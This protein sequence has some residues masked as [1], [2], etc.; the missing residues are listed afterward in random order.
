MSNPRVDLYARWGDATNYIYSDAQ[1][2]N[3]FVQ[4]L[5][6]FKE[7]LAYNNLA[8]ELNRRLRANHCGFVAKPYRHPGKPGA[9]YCTAWIARNRILTLPTD[10]V[11]RYKLGVAVQPNDAYTSTEFFSNPATFEK[12]IKVIL[13]SSD[14]ELLPVQSNRARR[15]FKPVN[16]SAF[17]EKSVVLAIIDDAVAI[18]HPEFLDAI[19]QSRVGL[20]WDQTTNGFAASQG[21]AVPNFGYTLL[22]QDLPLVDTKG[23]R[24]S[25]HGTHVASLA[26]G[27]TSPSYRARRDGFAVAAAAPL[28]AASDVAMAMV[29][30]PNLT[31]ADTSGGALGVNVLDAITF[32][33]QNVPAAAH[34]VVNLSFGHHAGPHNGTSVLE[35]ALAELVANYKNR[36]TI[37]LPAGNSFDSQCH[38]SFDVEKND[39]HTLTWRVLPEDKTPSYLEIWLPAGSQCDVTVTNPQGQ[40]VAAN[41]AMNNGCTWPDGANV[42]GGVWLD[43]NPANGNGKQ[44][45]LVAMAPTISAASA[46]GATAKPTALHGDWTIQ[47][48]NRSDNKKIQEAH[49]WVERDNSS[50]GRKNKGRQSYLVDANRARERRAT[51]PMPSQITGYGSLNAI[52]TGYAAVVVGAYEVRSG[53]ASAYSG[54]GTNSG[55][56]RSPDLAA[57]GEITPLLKG[58]LGVGNHGTGMVRLS[59]TS[60]AAPLYTR[61]FINS[62]ATSA[63][64]SV[65]TV[66]TVVAGPCNVTTGYHPVTGRSRLPL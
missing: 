66:A 15:T 13:N 60:V 19:G 24:A 53:K 47:I 59:G 22:K 16:P 11:E 6:E 8:E 18:D 4:V 38:A 65:A 34:L 21:G 64:D 50:F 49:A 28:D 7:K 12:T 9:R 43:S 25:Y 17:D 45:V 46:P 63:A 36:L 31:V 20:W 61:S 44:M 55:S 48:H 14:D 41:I 54:A 57:P 26:G 3:W 33:L 39:H 40:V 29:M 32:L 42:T 58:V 52:A 56:L 2:P 10:L 35:C 51:A 30:L 27:R 37:V 1:A 5:I 62:I 23:L